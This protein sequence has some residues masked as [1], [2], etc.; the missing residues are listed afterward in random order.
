MKNLKV[1]SAILG[2][3]L[4]ALYSTAS[5]SASSD[6]FGGASF[7]KDASHG[8]IGAVTATNG[9]ITQEGFLV[10]GSAGAGQYDYDNRNVA[11]G[12]VE[13]NFGSIDLLGGYQAFFQ[14]NQTLKFY[15]GGSWE[16]HQLSPKDY[17][18]EVRGTEFGLKSQV[19]Y[20]ANFN[21]VVTNAI[22][23]YSTGF[24]TYFTLANVG[25]D[26]GG[27]AFGPEV[28]FLGNE[29]F[30]QQRVGGFLGNIEIGDVILSL[31][32]GYAFASGV[33]EQSIYGGFNFT[34]R[35]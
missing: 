8:F 5:N 35:F 29:G 27:F 2:L 7:I 13:T 1:T 32:S 9:D 6:V 14:N 3:G 16:N 34:R 19:E 11:G 22:G 24:D 15:V 17:N 26:F 25:Y 20:Y 31:S 23:A 21:N 30:H 18:A 28:A 4:I 12:D 10:R 33:A